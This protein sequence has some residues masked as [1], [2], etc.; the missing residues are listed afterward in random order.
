MS[1][2][3]LKFRPMDPGVGGDLALFKRCFDANGSPR[4]EDEVAW[5]YRDNPAGHAV[6]QFAVDSGAAEEKLAA[7]YAVSPRTFKV[8]DAVVPAV[9]SIDTMT[10]EAHRGK[11][12]FLTLARAVYQRCADAGMPFVYGFPNGKSAHGFFQRLGWRAMNP[13]PFLFRPL[14]AKYFLRRAGVPAGV[15]RLVPE[16]KLPHG[17]GPALRGGERVE[18]VRAFDARF[19][20]LWAEFSAGIGV[21]IHRDSRYL[22]WRFRKPVEEYL[23]LGC[24]DG[25]RLLGFVVYTIKEK[26]GGRVGYVMELIHRP[27]MQRVGEALLGHAVH[28]ALRAGADVLLAWCMEHSPNYAAYRG[29]GFY[30][31]PERARPI[32]LHFGVCPLG[33]GVDAAVTQRT[34]WYLSY[35]DSDT[36]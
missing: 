27:G 31:L 5:E 12:L 29:R 16:V 21:G 28:E 33:D 36:V 3:D 10:D 11:G 4:R 20:A 13:V 32:E 8:G 14:R 18:P 7:T 34:S 30:P 24:F 35:C 9:Q 17:R 25:D 23:A 22:A 2:S 19:D 26:H 6:V 15:L 1:Q